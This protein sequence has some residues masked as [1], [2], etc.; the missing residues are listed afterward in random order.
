MRLQCSSPFL[1]LLLICLSHSVHADEEPPSANQSSTDFDDSRPRPKEKRQLLRRWR[2]QIRN[3]SAVVADDNAAAVINDAPSNPLNCTYRPP[4]RRRY[5]MIWR[6]KQRILTRKA[7]RLA[8]L[9]KL[10]YWDFGRDGE[11]CTTC[12]ALADDPPPSRPLL[13]SK[14]EKALRMSPHQIFAG[15]V[16]RFR[17]QFCRM[18]YNLARI[19]LIL[20]RRHKA[21]RHEIRPSTNSTPSLLDTPKEKCRRS[22]LDRH[23]A[24]RRYQIEWTLQNWHEASLPKIRWHDTD[25]IIA[26]SGLS[27]IVLSFA[28]TA[29]AADQFTN[30]QTFE[31]VTHSGLFGGGVNGTNSTISGSIHRGFLNAYSRVVRGTILR[32]CNAASPSGEDMNNT[33]A[34]D[35]RHRCKTSLTKTLHRRYDDCIRADQQGSIDM[36]KSSNETTATKWRR[37]VFKKKQGNKEEKKVKEKKKKKSRKLVGCQSHGEKLMDILREL[38]TDGLESGHTVH[39]DGHSLGGAISTL[40]ALDVIINLKTVPIQKLHLWTFGAPEVADSMFY[41]T[42]RKASPRLDAFLRD[43]RRYHRFVTRADNCATDFVTTI[44]SKGLNRRSARRLGGV[45]GDVA[46]A[47]EPAYIPLRHKPEFKVTTWKII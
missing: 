11:E 22:L 13:P 23:E 35:Q 30:V 42:E 24:G 29:S 19:I 12:F 8:V 16:M 45:K 39:L 15:I 41:E 25:L 6:R 36:L 3:Q 14:S 4:R 10:A 44:A 7:Y 40:L 9:A 27:E 26:T 2:E 46:H 32:I 28:G 5:R 21:F 43:R 37:K 47:V 38:V 20:R 17:M 31:P 33:T 18:R 34:V 1:L